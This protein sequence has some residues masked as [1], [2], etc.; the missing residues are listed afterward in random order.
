ML[1]IFTK[2]LFLYRS[3]DLNHL[4]VQ[5]KSGP[6][7]CSQQMSSLPAGPG[8]GLVGTGLVLVYSLVEDLAHWSNQLKNF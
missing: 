5:S 1:F 2:R 6:Q 4:Q 8:P 7:N 3:L